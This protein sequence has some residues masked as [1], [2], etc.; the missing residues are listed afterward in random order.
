MTTEKLIGS[1]QILAESLEKTDKGVSPYLSDL[2]KDH[3]ISAANHLRELSSKLEDAHQLNKDT[4]EILY[5][6]E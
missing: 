5:G 6:R 1:L 3:L 4:F 2:I